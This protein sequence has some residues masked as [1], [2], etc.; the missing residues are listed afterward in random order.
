MTKDVAKKVM[1]DKAMWIAVSELVLISLG[2]LET[3]PAALLGAFVIL[4]YVSITTS[5]KTSA[6]QDLLFKQ[7]VSREKVNYE[8]ELVIEETIRNKGARPI[9]LEV[10]TELPDEIVVS[11]G[12]NHYVTYLRGRETRRIR[13]KVKPSFMGHFTVQRAS[14]RSMD[15]FLAPLDEG[16]K[17]LDTTFSVV[18]V[19][20]EFRKFPAG[21][22]NVK[23]LQGSIPSK[24]PGVGTDFFEIRDYSPSDEFR[25]INWKASARAGAL[26]SNE[27]EWERMADIYMILD[28]TSSS[29]YFLKDYIKTCASI[30][31]YFLKLGNRVGLLAVGKFWTWVRSGSGRKQLIRV[32]ENLIDQRSGESAMFN[33][34]FE[35]T[36]RAMP[37]ASTVIFLSPMR[38]PRIRE[39]VKKIFERRQRVLTMIPTHGANKLRTS[40]SDSTPVVTAKKIAQLERENAFKFLKRI[41][42]PTIEWDPGLPLAITM[43]A[44]E[45]W[46]GRTP[47]ASS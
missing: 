21:R 10:L 15:F 45:R 40:G 41:G 23:P 36:L 22:I 17:D 44:F 11:E 35:N 38:D 1:T 9:F 37:Q 12:S 8:E 13:Y 25:R 5:F 34:Q 39:L 24:S 18:P 33:I 42:V 32:V 27:Y 7:R 31:N 6:L 19:L 4:L 20:E 43:E 2:F 46:Q 29:T 14:I 26:L 30:A 47:I 3:L 16:K 28:S